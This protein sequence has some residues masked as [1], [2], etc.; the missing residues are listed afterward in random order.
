MRR[1]IF[2][3]LAL[4][5]LAWGA[6][7]LASYMSSERDFVWDVDTQYDGKDDEPFGSQLFDKMAEATAP[8]GYQF[9]GDDLEAAL[10]PGDRKSLLVIARQIFWD[11]LMIARLDSFVRQGNKVMVVTDPYSNEDLQ[12]WAKVKAN[13]YH[14][15]RFNKNDFSNYLKGHMAPDTLIWGHNTALVFSQIITSRMWLDDFNVETI[16][17][18]HPCM[19]NGWAQVASVARKIGKGQLFLVC[20]PLLFTN[21]GVLD[22]QISRYVSYH[23]NMIA[24]LP[25]VRVSITYQWMMRDDVS[26]QSTSPLYFMLEHPPFRWAL[27]TIVTVLVLLMFFTA[28]RRQRIIPVIPPRINR[29]VEF[30][31]LLG[32]IYFRRYDNADLLSKKYT[33]FREDLRRKWMID[34]DDNHMLQDNVRELSQRTGLSESDISATLANLR[35]LSVEGRHVSERELMDAIRQIN[36]ITKHL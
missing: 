19:K 11:S 7:M 24:D 9:L 35:Q 2:L 1:T 25:I 17:S 12:Q 14:N 36:E 10:K 6:W 16:S 3:V 34:L 22:D 18:H 15:E 32:T 27:Y 20:N 23:L 4:A 5:V 33:Y 28:R 8:N 26:E 29:N 30:V 31:R 21:Y 13:F